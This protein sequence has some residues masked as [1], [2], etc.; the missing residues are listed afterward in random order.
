MRPCKDVGRAFSATLDSVY[1]TD[2]VV[3][4]PSSHAWSEAVGQGCHWNRLITE[5]FLYGQRTS[6]RTFLYCGLQHATIRGPV[7]LA[8]R[9][10]VVGWR[11]LS[12]QTLHYTKM[13]YL[14]MRLQSHVAVYCTACDTG[15]TVFEVADGE[16]FRTDS[17]G[18][19]LTGLPC[20]GG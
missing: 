7:F 4:R 18:P 17:V 13:R 11:L 16:D 6:H 19:A 3:A 15:R 9:P 14:A 12:L 1:N 10:R 20:I 5:F 8:C 2:L